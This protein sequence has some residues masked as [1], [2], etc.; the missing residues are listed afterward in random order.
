M[1]INRTYK[2]GRIK[3]II[4]KSIGAY[5]RYSFVNY[6]N[7]TKG[8]G[9]FSS[10]MT[11]D[12]LNVELV[13]FVNNASF[14]DLL[15]S[16]L[17]FLKNCGV[18]KKWTL[19]I[20]DEFSSSNKLILE[21]CP[22]LEIRRWDSLSDK[23]ISLNYAGKWQLRK[24]F[25]YASYPIVTSTIFIDS[26]VIF[27]SLFKKYFEVIKCKNWYLPEPPECKNYDVCAI[28]QEGII[29]NMYSVNA[30]FLIINHPINWEIGFEYIDKS[31]LNN[32][33]SYF[34][35]QTALN[36]IYL[37]DD[38]AQILDPRLFHASAND[39]FYISALNTSEFAIRHYVGLIRHKMW[40]LGWKQFI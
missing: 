30:G 15:L 20:D 12:I 32:L 14:S 33:D 28:Y 24:Y 40:Q 10:N 3:S 8:I 35:D 16:I 25:S 29:G 6:L 13:T 1:R 17:S 34:I 5:S 37:S 7:R 9:L 26:D 2:F 23:I 38:N 22:F 19:L 27:Y 21:Q 18:P 36:L 31:I 39:H 11:A 4:S